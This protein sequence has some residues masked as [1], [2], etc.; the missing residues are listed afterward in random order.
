MINFYSPLDPYSAYQALRDAGPIHWDNEFFGGAWLLPHYVDVINVL[1]D[2][3]F[4]VK[5]AGRWINSTGPGAREEL[6]EFKRIFARSLIFLD[7]THHARLRKVMS[8]GFKP[9]ALTRLTPRIQKIV[10]GLVEQ[11]AN[12]V[13]FDFM[14]E[15]AR[16]L[17]A[18]V[19]ADM[20]AIDPKDQADFIA[21][22]DDIAHFIGSP[23]ASIDSARVAQR[24]LVAL[25]E[26]FRALLPARR[27]NLGD[28]LISDFIRAESTGGVTTSKELLAQCCTLLFA[29][30]ETTRNLLGNGLFHLLHDRSRYQSLQDHPTLLPSAIRELL[31]YDSP[32]QFTGRVLSV[33]LDLHGKQ[34][35]KG[36]LVIPLIGSANRDAQRF[37]DPDRLDFTRDQGMHLSFG[38][39]AHVCLGATLT[40][41]EAEIA[42]TSLMRTF[43]GMRLSP[44]MPDWAS[45]PV[46]RGLR[47]LP[48]LSGQPGHHN[49]ASHD[50]HARTAGKMPGPS[51]VPSPA[52]TNMEA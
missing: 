39:G 35:K 11:L 38:Y 50:D 14:R 45:N 21:W 19:I 20:L 48:V 23:T 5:R 9:A 34:L 52:L 41:L 10:D 43:P 31:R 24:S 25:N 17:P 8:S 6:H 13:E 15:F 2:S 46:Y 1:R 28:D 37:T 3:R 49:G 26:Y 51:S 32:L 40:H 33:N 27:L 22:S 36:D 16:P 42:F 4:S 47:T 18:L 44:G 30:H 7:G 29:G 12:R